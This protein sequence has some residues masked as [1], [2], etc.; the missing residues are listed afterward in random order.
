[1]N[2]LEEQFFEAFNNPE[3]YSL[4]GKPGF[5]LEAHY[6]RIS[7]KIALELADKAFVAG[8]SKSSFNQFKQEVLGD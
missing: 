1:M 4:H 2:K 3:A 8:R 5:E 6:A 7:A